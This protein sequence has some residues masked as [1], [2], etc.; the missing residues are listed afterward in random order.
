MIKKMCL[1]LTFV[2]LL[3]LS[4]CKPP[5]Q[6]DGP[7]EI[8]GLHGTIYQIFV[9]SFADSDGD[10]IGDLNGITQKLDY[11]AS[12]NIKALWLMPIQPSSAYHGYEVTDYYDINPQ[13]GTLDDFKNLV[14]KAKEKGIEI[15]LDMVLNHTSNQHP[16]FIE[17]MKGDPKYLNY[18]VTTTKSMND[19]VDGR[20]VWHRNGTYSYYAYF[21]YT[22]PDLN[23]FNPEVQEE[24]INIGKFW[25]NL[26][27]KGFRLDGAM[28]FYATREYP[29]QAYN[30]FDNV[31]F[32]NKL[33]T[34]MRKIDPD[35]YTLGEVW[36][37]ANSYSLYYQSL[38]SALDF[39]ISDLLVD[40]ASKNGND[41]YVNKIVRL[42]NMYR[43]QNPDFIGAPFLRNHDMDR[44]A[45]IAGIDNNL[46]K[47]RM[48]AEMLLT[49]PGNP[50]IYYGEE[51]G[52]KGWKTDGTN[53]WYDET[54]RLP[55]IWDDSYETSWINTNINQGVKSP[56]VQA[57]DANS[58]WNTY[59]RILKVRAENKALLYGN[60]LEP[61]ENNNYR[62][63]GY[64]RTYTNGSE[65]QKVLIIHNLDITPQNISVTGKILY[66]TNQETAPE[67]VTVLPSKTTVI[68]D[69]TDSK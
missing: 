12:L 59:R 8:S 15:I 53:G 42:Y 34:E 5:T 49:L 63:Q 33:K 57:A 16:W 65:T 19:T 43:E 37:D 18:Y 25:V 38:D 10:G 32:I 48:A 9:R 24:L 31:L 30:W 11:L 60:N 13:Y 54:R 45:S 27:V 69:V 14:K 62:V 55:F 58:L 20:Q 44:L 4:G 51:I 41:N 50:I 26:G 68:I 64:Y 22:Q 61:Y 28:H 29:D 6:G 35:F 46:A 21:F 1:L 66:L 17:A 56:S 40:T 2:S 36:T 47:M 3:V 67:T 39:D 23:F 52:M 7:K